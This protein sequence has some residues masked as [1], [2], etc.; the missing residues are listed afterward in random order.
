MA[1]RDVII[2]RCED[3]TREEVRNLIQAGFTTIEEIKRIS[4]MGMGPCQGRT[5]HQLLVREISELTG[6][7]AGEIVPA[8]ARPPIKGIKLG[9]LLKGGEKHD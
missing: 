5:C 1:D 3:I 9:T 4:R 6:K 2:C 7:K 8:I